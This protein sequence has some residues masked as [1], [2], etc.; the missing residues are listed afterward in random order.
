MD[1]FPA[2]EMAGTVQR[3]Q[4]ALDLIGLDGIIREPRHVLCKHIG[5]GLNVADVM[6]CR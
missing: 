1:E 4:H 3:E 6:L 5:L 2:A